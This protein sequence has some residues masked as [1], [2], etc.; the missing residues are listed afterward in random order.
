MSVVN[1]LPQPGPQLLDGTSLSTDGDTGLDSIFIQG[2][3]TRG[4]IVG[5]IIDGGRDRGPCIVEKGGHSQVANYVPFLSGLQVAD[6]EIESLQRIALEDSN[7]G[8][9][10]CGLMLCGRS[11][12]NQGQDQCCSN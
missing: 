3:D 10:S 9:E 4:N 7:D 1:G 11:R 5:R 12:R 8:V 2:V 6:L